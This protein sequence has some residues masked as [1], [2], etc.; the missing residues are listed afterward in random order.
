MSVNSPIYL[1]YLNVPVR[2]HPTLGDMSSPNICFGDVIVLIPNSRE[3]YQPLLKQWMNKKKLL[4]MGS[5]KC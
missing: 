1:G 2:Y 3:I 4:K 5:E